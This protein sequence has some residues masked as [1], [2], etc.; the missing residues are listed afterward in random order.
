MFTAEQTK[1]IRD[2]I[3]KAEASVK[4][5]EATIAQLKTAGLPTASQETAL[6]QAKET[7]AKYKKA[8]A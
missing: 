4:D 6:T 2:N 5:F 8:F 1:I 3:A 7:L